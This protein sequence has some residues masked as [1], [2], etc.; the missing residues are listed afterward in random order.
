V[1]TP[2]FKEPIAM[3]LTSTSQPSQAAALRD[4]ASTVRRFFAAWGAGDVSTAEA[5]VVDNVVLG[6]IAG[7]LYARDIYPGREGI[8]AAF[9]EVAARW[10]RFEI[11]VDE[12]WARD[13][14]VIAVV[15]LIFE[16]HGMSSGG[17]I[18]VACRLRDGLIASVQDDAS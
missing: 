10:D 17:P 16:K 2:A 18:T 7:L 13:G 1:P 11:T 15:H 3:T 4:D 12:T 9:G 8:A 14:Q 6:P 5:L